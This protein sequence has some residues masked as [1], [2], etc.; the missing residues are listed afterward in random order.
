LD[1][2]YSDEYQAFRQEVAS[3]IADHRHLA[4]GGAVRRPGEETGIAW[5]KLLIE[6]GY[7]AR[8]VPA[9][10]GGFGAE[11]DIL[12]SHI[13]A[14]EFARAKVRPGHSGDNRLVPTLLELGTEEQKK[15]YIPPTIRG[16]MSWCQ[17]YSEP[18]SGSDLASLSTR[19]VVD[20][21]DFVI[22]GQK[23]WTSGAKTADMM[24]CLV[25]TE[26]DAPKHQGISYL[27][28]PTDTPGI[29]IRPM[30]QMTGDSH[31]NEVFFTDVR[32]PTSSIV[33][34]RGE[35]WFVAN[36]TLK[37]ERG[38][39]GDPHAAEARFHEIV[40]LMQQ[41]T[42]GGIR[43]MDHAVYRDRLLKLQARML[44]MKFNGM[45]VLTH[46]SRG[47]DAGLPRWI[48]KLQGCELNHQMAAMAIDLLGE[49]GILYDASP[50]IRDA[51][52]WQHRYMMDLGLIIGGGTAQIQKNMI[53]ERALG[54]PKEPKVEE[55]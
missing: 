18:G 34:R 31:F 50:Y 52:M 23:I 21:D 47:E 41:E 24:F 8:T 14:E 22:N 32:V 53:G 49:L 15:Q 35:G 38:G 13:I 33:G 6:H 29:D 1:L 42:I 25:R 44:S 55:A 12:K 3:F 10:Y 51:G 30:V 20:G 16:E 45:R 26:R 2:A 5:Q 37:H 54:L 27:L 7:A 46:N 36:A 40:E 11:P 43:L 4:P 39:L 19:A 9:E 48:V 17:G 28:F